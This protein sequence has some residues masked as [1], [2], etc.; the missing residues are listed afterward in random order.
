MQAMMDNDQYLKDRIDAMPNGV[1]GVGSRATDLSGITSEQWFGFNI[2]IVLTQQRTLKITLTWWAIGGGANNDIFTF[3]IKEGTVEGQAPSVGIQSCNVICPIAGS[4]T[5]GGTVVVTVIK[6]PGTFYY[7]ASC[8]R[9]SGTGTGSITSTSFHPAQ[10]I[11]EDIG[12][13]ISFINL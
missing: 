2:P 11:V 5:S 8:A 6:G 12:P 3:R 4:G 13:P 9:A 10:L 7:D 1:L